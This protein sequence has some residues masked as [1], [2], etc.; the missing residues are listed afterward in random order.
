[1]RFLTQSEF[2]KRWGRKEKSKE[3][4]KFWA[5][6]EARKEAGRKRRTRV[7]HGLKAFANASSKVMGAL[8]GKAG[9]RAGR[10]VRVL[11]RK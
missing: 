6:G 3:M 10:K 5:K 1:M 4:K 7:R 8:T 11:R 9:A 2:N